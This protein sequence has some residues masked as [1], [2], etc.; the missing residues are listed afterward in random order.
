M[1]EVLR[2]IIKEE[3]EKAMSSTY[4]ERDIRD[5]IM[6]KHFIHT[7]NGNVYSPV[8]FQN[9]FVVGVNNNSEHIDVPLTEVAFI[10]SSV[11]RFGK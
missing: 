5:A 2:H 3:L 8:S 9:D 10:Q 1:E 11:D 4:G 6:N 7:R